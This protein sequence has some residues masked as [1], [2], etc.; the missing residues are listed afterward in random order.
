[1]FLDFNKLLI[2]YVII[3]SIEVF[4]L[5][6]MVVELLFVYVKVKWD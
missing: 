5:E 3:M 2:F 1:M 6:G 4:V